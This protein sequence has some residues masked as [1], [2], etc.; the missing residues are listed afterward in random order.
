MAAPFASPDDIAARW[1][2]LT[3]AE[4]TVATTLA[5]DASALIRA[6]FPGID[7]QAATGAVDPDVLRMVCAGIVKRALVA[8]D[9]GVSQESE[10]AGPF[11]RSQTYAN[12]MR[13][14]FLTQAEITLIIGYKPRA[15]SVGYANTTRRHSSGAWETWDDV[16][17]AYDGGVA[18]PANPGH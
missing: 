11:S 5:A 15:T 3:D 2:P 4:T 16:T 10:T 12:P 13:N 9:D 1:R 17:A 8:P 14:V 7:A 6:R 18:F